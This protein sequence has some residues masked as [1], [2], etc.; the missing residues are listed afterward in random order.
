MPGHKMQLTNEEQ[1]PEPGSRIPSKHLY[2]FRA[3]QAFFCQPST[4]RWNGMAKE[5]PRLG[6]KLV[7]DI[8]VTVCWSGVRFS[9]K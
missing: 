8:V 3:C 4:N 1:D 7:Q 6:S 9:A 2:G 5:G